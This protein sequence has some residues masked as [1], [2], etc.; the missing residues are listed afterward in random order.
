M[1]VVA[2]MLVPGT[3]QAAPQAA[4][5]PKIASYN[6]FM[7]S[8]LLYP[9]WGQL[10]RADLIADQ[11]VLAGQD[12]V[13]VNEAFDN[14]ASDRLLGNLAGEYPHQ[15]PVVGRSRS[16]WDATEG[17]YTSVAPED[18]GVAVLSRW[19]IERRVQFVYTEGCGADAL[20]NKGFAYVRLR[21]PDGPLHVVGTH[22]Q[23]E[24]S[25]CG[26][27]EAAEVRVTQRAEITAFLQRAG[28]PAS[29]PVYVGGDLNVVGA[30]QEY[31]RML[32]D[33][34]ARTPRL[35]GH[36]YSWD[37]ST[38]TVCADQY[39]A[40]DPPEQLDYVLSVDGHPGPAELVNETRAVQSPQWS[41][42]SWGTTYTYTDYSDHY[43]V[44]AG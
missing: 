36:P 43:P 38:N 16:G 21:T 4:A 29:E 30:S 2:A 26:D 11:G 22:Q 13:I 39:D 20:A 42:R 8:R 35:T 33:L 12:V 27:G 19:P 31:G 25:T 17:E 10:Q 6:V 28:V 14:A 23:A 7:L 5:T 37:C 34:D 18:G 24:D 3:A 41:V 9:N 15:T 44:F 32:G 1:L 40:D